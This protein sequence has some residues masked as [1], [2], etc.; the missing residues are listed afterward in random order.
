MREPSFLL[1]LLPF[2]V[3]LQNTKWQWPFQLKDF[4]CE[5]S[6]VPK[7]HTTECLVLMGCKWI[8]K[9][10]H[11]VAVHCWGIISQMLT[12]TECA[13]AG[14]SDMFC[15]AVVQTVLLCWAENGSSQNQWL[16]C[17]RASM[18]WSPRNSQMKC[19]RKTFCL[20]FEQGHHMDEH[21]RRL[22]HIKWPPIW[23]NNVI[24]WVSASKLSPLCFHFSSTEPLFCPHCVLIVSPLCPH[25]VPV[26]PPLH[27]H[28]V[29]P[30]PL[31]PHCVPI[32][33]SLCPHCVSIV[34]S[35]SLLCLHCVFILSPLCPHCVSIVSPTVSLL[36]LNCVP[37]LSFLC[38][39]NLHCVPIVS[40]QAC[41]CARAISTFPTHGPRRPALL[42]TMVER[43]EKPQG[44][45]LWH[46]S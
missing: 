44:I 25:C 9:G 39:L 21:L 5:V 1:S 14:I 32:V 40:S 2:V 27:L 7:P 45:V 33:S 16:A 15:K 34:H 10:I 26:M 24:A 13:F 30:F 28:C 22:E 17:W 23:C 36:H 38:P 8:S 42:T 43:G 18:D 11:I 12:A 6:Q 20:A 19:C 29:L 4:C 37:I 35:F 3:D 31:C 46:Q 41:A